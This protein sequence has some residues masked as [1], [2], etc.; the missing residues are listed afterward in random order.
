[1]LTITWGAIPTSRRVVQDGKL[2]TAA[3]VSAG[4]DMALILV[5]KLAGT[6]IAETLQLVLEYD[7]KPPFDMGSP[8]KADPAILNALRARLKQS[9]QEKRD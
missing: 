3:G 7:P 9:M 2:I 8:E 1:M 6:A 5:E 4:L